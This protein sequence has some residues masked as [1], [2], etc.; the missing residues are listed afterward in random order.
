MQPMTIESASL[1]TNRDG[2]GDVCLLLGAAD[3]IGYAHLWPHARPWQLKR[4][5]PA[6]RGLADARTVAHVLGN[7][8]ADS[9]AMPRTGQRPD[10][11]AARARS[12]GHDQQPLAA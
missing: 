6:L 7:A 3:R 8:L 5:Q 11:G 2:S 1:R 4:T 9:A 10:P 12:S